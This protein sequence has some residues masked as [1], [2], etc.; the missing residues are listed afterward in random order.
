MTVHCDTSSVKDFRKSK[1][2]FLKNSCLNRTAFLH[3]EY[4]GNENDSYP[5]EMV[6]R[7]LSINVYIDKVAIS[8]Q[9]W[10]W[11]IFASTSDHFDR[12]KLM[13]WMVMNNSNPDIT[14]ILHYW[15]NL[16]FSSYYCSPNRRTKDHFGSNLT[17]A[18]L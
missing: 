18:M 15:Y 14:I 8:L 7:I 1:W 11:S 9:W 16:F 13:D 10:L 17:L 5:M 6:W 2:K 3:L 4:G 12:R